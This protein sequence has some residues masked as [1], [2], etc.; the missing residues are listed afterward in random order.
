MF[1][2]GLQPPVKPASS[3]IVGYSLLMLLL[4]PV[5]TVILPTIVGVLR[6]ANVVSIILLLRGYIAMTQFS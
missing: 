1:Q 4:M 2:P 3:M 5:Q 6:H